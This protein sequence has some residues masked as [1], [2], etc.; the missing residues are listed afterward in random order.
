MPVNDVV[1]GE[2]GEGGLES[3]GCRAGN[4]DVT[5]VRYLPHKPPLNDLLSHP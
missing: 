4:G 5:E 2:G 3:H 1:D